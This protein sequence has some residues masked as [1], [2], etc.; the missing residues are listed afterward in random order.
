VKPA[1]PCDIAEDYGL[2]GK[3]AEANALIDQNKCPFV[4]LVAIKQYAVDP[5]GAERLV[6]GTSDA[7]DRLIGLDQLAVE[8]AK[9]GAI[10]EALRFLGDLQNIESAARNPVLAENSVS[11]A[12]HGIA[13][14]WTIKNGPKVV[15][16][17][18]RS[19]PTGEQRTWALIGMA[20]ALGHASP[21]H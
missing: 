16:K 7:D 9:K 13:R 11:D 12:V 6:R 19:R 21:A 5:A 20:Q 8:A 14:Y 10:A 17:W 15:L 1:T 3:F 2:Q 4:S 18:A